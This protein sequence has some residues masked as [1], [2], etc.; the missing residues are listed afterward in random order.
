MRRDLRLAWP[1]SASGWPWP[2]AAGPPDGDR[3]ASLSGDGATGTTNGTAKDPEQGPP[4]GGPR[5]RQVHARARRRHARPG[6]RRAGPDPGEDRRAAVPAR[7]RPARPQ[8]ARGGP[9]GVRRPDGRRRRRPQDRPGGARRH[10]RLRQVHARARHRHARPDRRGRPGHA[11]ATTTRAG[12]TPTREKF[13]QAEQACDHHLANLGRDRRR[14]REPVVSARRPGG[15][16]WPPPPGW[17]WPARPGGRGRGPG[18]KGGGQDTGGE[19][20]TATAEVTRRDLRAQEEVD[21]TLGYGEARRGGQPAR[22]HHHRAARRGGDGHHG[23]RRC[24]GSTASRCRCCTARCRP[25]GTL[26][27]GVDDGPDVRQLEQNLVALGYDPDRAITVDDHFTWATTAA[28]RRWQETAR[29]RRDRRPSRRA[30]PSGSPARSGSAPLKAAVGDKARPGSPLL[31]VT[32]TGRRV[33]ID[34]D[35]SR[36]PYVKAGDRVDLEL[37][38]GRTTTGRVVSVGTVATDPGRRRRATPTRPSSWSSPSTSPRPPAASTRPRWTPRSPPRPRGRAR[39][40]GRRA[41]RPGRGR[42]RGR[43]RRDGRR[44]LVGGGDRPVRRRPGRGHR[45]R[46]GR[47]R[48]VVVPA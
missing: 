44:E 25:G 12:P 22:R 19:V 40:A 18:A 27:V 16:P 23:A 15:W 43:G 48:P 11:Q 10:G 4:A 45:R 29:A 14:V 20:A 38:G 7:R 26:S 46:P 32:G 24:T 28:V 9:E 6:G 3:V 34:L 36:Q 47:G 21:G 39:R 5:L 30:T 2:P 37:P 33:T 8:E 31:E 1:C 41:A 35:A 13:Q 42:L 17:C